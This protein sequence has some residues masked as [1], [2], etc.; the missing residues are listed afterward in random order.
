MRIEEK[1][2]KGST[3]EIIF[4]PMSEKPSKM[5]ILNIRNFNEISKLMLESDT[6]T[7]KCKSKPLKEKKGKQK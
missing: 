5:N 7:E 2:T 4:E 6:K 3:E 1:E